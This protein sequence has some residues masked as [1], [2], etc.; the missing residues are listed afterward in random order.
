[1]YV[2]CGGCYLSKMCS[3]K[4]HTILTL[5]C[6]VTS[7]FRNSFIAFTGSHQL[8]LFPMFQIQ[9]KLQRKVFGVRFWEKVERAS[10]EN[11]FGQNKNEFNP[12]HVQVLL[13]T[14]QTGGAVAVL[15]HTGDPN[16]G[17][18]DW[19]ENQKDQDDNMEAGD[20]YDAENG[21]RSRGLQRWSSIRDRKAKAAQ[22]W[23][24]VRR[25]IATDGNALKQNTIEKIRELRPSKS[26][27]KVQYQ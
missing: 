17:L 18:R 10:K 1:M 6:F 3:T 14:Y 9:R 8:L 13:R 12:R 22:Q 24:S 15:S 4:S 19:Y 2:S 26:R 23:D 5:S 25:S 7:T 20:N 11:L 21:D 16:K 27:R